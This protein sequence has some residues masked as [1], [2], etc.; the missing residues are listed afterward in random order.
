MRLSILLKFFE[1]ENPSIEFGFRQGS[2]EMGVRVDIE[3]LICIAL[4]L[5]TM[6]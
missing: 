5:K 6:T 4:F 3:N 2:S 1:V